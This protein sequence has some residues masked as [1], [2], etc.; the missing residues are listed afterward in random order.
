MFFYILPEFYFNNKY[1]FFLLQGEYT[2][3]KI[4]FFTTSTLD[5]NIERI[6]NIK[7]KNKLIVIWNKTK[8]FFHG[9]IPN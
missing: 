8:F 6:K 3:K 4:H 1:K 2:G 7:Y 5:I 9:S